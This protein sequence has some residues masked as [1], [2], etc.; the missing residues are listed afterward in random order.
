[1]RGAS[2]DAS[3]P[4]VNRPD[5]S[6]P[7]GSAPDVSQPADRLRRGR[8]V[9]RAVAGLALLGAAAVLVLGLVVAPTDAVQGDAQR[10]MYVHV[11]AAWVAYLAFAGVLLASALYL[12]RRDLR[13]DVRARAAAEIGVGLTALAIVLG[14]LWGRVTWGVWWTWDA[15]V[16]TTALL[17]LVYLGYLAVRTLSTDLATNAR[18]CAVVGVLAFVNVPLVHFS[19]LWWRTLHQPPTVLG[20]QAADPPIDPVMGLTLA[21]GVVAFTAGAVAVY[22]LRVRGLRATYDGFLDP[23]AADEG[24]G[25]VEPAEPVHVRRAVAP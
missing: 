4:E 11:P 23:T 15:R 5:V 8:L 19:V 6:R 17:L 13:W 22:R 7:A 24:G 2:S 10:L 21:V 16:V 9:D 14:A 3:P 20:A 25:Q 12:A 1:M 18:R